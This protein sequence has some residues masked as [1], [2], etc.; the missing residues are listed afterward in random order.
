MD[1]VDFVVVEAAV[2]VVVTA[3][4]RQTDLETFKAARNKSGNKNRRNR[5]LPS[6]SSIRTFCNATQLPSMSRYFVS[7]DLLK[8][9]N[10]KA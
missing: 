2:V 8:E 10:E 7:V 1:S 4:D 3:A 9:E 5:P 6:S